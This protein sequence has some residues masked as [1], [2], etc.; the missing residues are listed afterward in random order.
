M[1]P[2]SSYESHAVSPCAV[3]NCFFSTPSKND[4][5]PSFN[6]TFHF[7]HLEKI[8][9]RMC[10]PSKYSS[11]YIYD[12]S[13]KYIMLFLRVYRAKPV[14]YEFDSNTSHDKLEER[15]C[16]FFNVAKKEP[17]ALNIRYFLCLK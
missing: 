9:S 3:C 17:T 14:F 13:F 16:I 12:I 10:V 4:F 1:S 6:L 7:K 8:H 5:F 15:N 2:I 11:I